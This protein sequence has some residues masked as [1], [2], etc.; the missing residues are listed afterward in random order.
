MVRKFFISF[1]FL[2]AA[3]PVFAAPVTA[4]STELELVSEVTSV[5]P[6][7]PFWVAL[8]MKMDD[9]WH[10]YWRN[11]GDAGISTTIEWT[12]LEGFAVGPIQWPY[13]NRLVIDPLV[14]Y[15][16]EGEVFLLSQITPSGN[17]LVGQVTL[18]G[19][20]EFLACKEIC[21][22]GEADVNLTLPL[23]GQDPQINPLWQTGFQETR[24]KLGRNPLG[25][26]VQVFEDQ[27]FYFF[28]MRSEE[29][30]DKSLD[31]LQFFPYRKDVIDHLANQ[32]VQKESDMQYSLAVEKSAIV[33]DPQE[34]L[35]G[36]LK[37]TEGWKGI[38]NPWAL[39]VDFPVQQRVQRA[40]LRQALPLRS[41]EGSTVKIVPVK[42]G[43]QTGI[44]LAFIFAFLGGLLLNL[45]P[46][47]LPVLS[48][49]VLH[50]VK[51][52]HEKS[53]QTIRHGVVF[54]LG[55]LTCFWLLA[56]GILIL[57]SLGQEIGWGFQFQSSGF[58]VGLSILF[59][60]LS[61]DLFGIFEIGTALTRLGGVS[62]AGSGLRHSFLSGM[63]TT[64]TATPCTAPFMGTAL[65]V[66]LGQP[67]TTTFLIFTGLGLGTAFPIL[68]LSRFPQLLRFIPKPGEWMLRLKQFL[69]F[70]LLATVLWLAWVLGLQKG[71]AAVMH[72][73]MGLLVIG[74]GLW[75]WGSWGQQI[76]EAR[77]RTVVGC[78]AVFFILSGLAL[79]L[80]GI[81]QDS[82]GIRKYDQIKGLVWQPYSPELIQDLRRQGKLVFVDFTA[83]WC[84]SCQVNERLVLND[85]N[86]VAKFKELD[87]ATVKA[88]WTS[89]D[90]MITEALAGLGKNSIPV[91]LIYPRDEKAGPI[92][93]PEVLTKGIV[94]EAL[95]KIKGD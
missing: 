47:V 59:F 18:Q 22:P 72:L 38:S 78:V 93:L 68:I 23:S 57:K 77:G 14:N 88:D 63:L 11:P 95:E 82:L 52:A 56:G 53:Q 39:E 34:R 37:I 16:Y 76:K 64:I 73:L 28:E 66:A 86:V 41:A 87:V 43:N 5:K 48:I 19:H 61:L 62:K 17:G 40:D 69:G 35:Q 20:V 45:M 31:E 2:L 89:R 74:V 29:L 42:T 44:F 54:T 71:L 83:A 81:A 94:I 50:L 15:V 33:H 21:V 84:L 51:Q 91:Y 25:W 79:C 4:A 70:L 27:K 7:Q 92:I 32:V 1:L 36:I 6:D 58:L 24:R 49:K 85:A 90:P 10:V 26:D 46:C 55:V 3:T 75:V 9:G 12:L 65:G 60:I 80:T 13:P 8:R 67:G 30:K